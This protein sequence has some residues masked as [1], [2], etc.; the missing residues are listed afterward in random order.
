MTGFFLD[1]RSLE[2]KIADAKQLLLDSGYIVRGPILHKSEINTPSKLVDFFYDRLALYNPDLKAMYSSNKKRD[3]FIAKEFI[4][5][6][7]EAGLNKKYAIAESCS[8]IDFLLQK[9]PLLHLPFKITSMSVL[10]QNGMS[11]VTKKL[12]DVYNGFNGSVLAE[13]DQLWFDKI[14][15]EQEKKDLTEKELA[16]VKKR[17]KIED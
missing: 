7:I 9:E 10:G 8:L 13:E 12:L 16:E 14:Y 15:K 4:E 17:L 6:R 2:Q 3:L 5:S 1:G 11:W